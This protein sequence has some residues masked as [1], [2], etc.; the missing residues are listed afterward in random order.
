MAEFVHQT[1]LHGHI[2]SAT[3]LRV[4]TGTFVKVSKQTVLQSRTEQDF[5]FENSDVDRTLKIPMF[6]SIFHCLMC[7]SRLRSVRLYV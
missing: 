2:T 5:D 6:L 7:L 4:I 1:R 3:V